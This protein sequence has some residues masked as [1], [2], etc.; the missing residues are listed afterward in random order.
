MN[1]VKAIIVCAVLF[2]CTLTVAT[3]FTAQATSNEA[4]YWQ[5]VSNSNDA[6]MYQAYLA[7]YPGG[8]FSDLAGLTLN[9]LGYYHFEVVT[10]PA[11]AQIKILNIGP[12]YSANTWLKPGKYHV[13]VSAAQH[14]S[15]TQWVT[16]TAANLRVVVALTVDKKK[17]AEVAAQQREEYVTRQVAALAQNEKKEAYRDAPAAVQISYLLGTKTWN[18]YQYLELWDKPMVA[19][20]ILN[21]LEQNQ[22][23]LGQR[24]DPTT[25]S[26]DIGYHTVA[27]Q[28]W[29]QMRKS[30][31][32]DEV[33]LGGTLY[34]TH[35]SMAKGL[36]TPNMREYAT[37]YVKYV[38][39]WE[40]GNTEDL[41]QIEKGFLSAIFLTLNR[42]ITDVDW[43]MADTTPQQEKQ[44]YITALLPQI[45][46]M[47]QGLDMRF[48]PEGIKNPSHPWYRLRLIQEASNTLIQHY[49]KQ[50]YDEGNLKLI[51]IAPVLIETKKT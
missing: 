7:K 50:T 20:G 45:T 3:P 49:N 44:Q 18:A 40:L 1:Y 12:K 46:Q 25:P 33:S 43:Y 21:L 6:A 8:E 38:N 2:T 35:L 47:K 9:Q 27:A 36:Q 48:P 17:V 4:I 29:T 30:N 31:D 23:P 10:T 39:R 19:A 26:F 42:P 51:T 22:T 13:A 41:K 5:T 24:I 32:R 15:T 37:A 16:L 34:A 11:A 28:L 14:L